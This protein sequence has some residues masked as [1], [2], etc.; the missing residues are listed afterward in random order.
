MPQDRMNPQPQQD[1]NIE[2]NENIENVDNERF[3]SDTQKIIRRHLENK[4]D[5]ITD[6]DIAGV[7]VGLVPPEFDSATEARFEGEEAREDVED[8][9]L[10]DTEDMEKDENVADEQ[11]TPW[12]TVDPKK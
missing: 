8:E 10:N 7:R 3:E 12:D 11:I 9:L 1:E 4:D 6:E 5:V 2:T